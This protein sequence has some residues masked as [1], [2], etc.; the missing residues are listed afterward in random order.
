MNELL[1]TMKSIICSNVVFKND[2]SQNMYHL[3]QS[4]VHLYVKINRTLFWFI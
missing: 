1:F 3:M 2:S 4:F